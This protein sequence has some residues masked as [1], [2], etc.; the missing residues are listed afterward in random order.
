MHLRE[1]LE[2]ADRTA[3]WTLNRLP[4]FADAEYQLPPIVQWTGEWPWYAQIRR[5]GCPA[6]V[7]LEDTQ[8]DYSKRGIRGIHVG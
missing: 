4:C 6:V 3:L 1:F 8:K 2:Q 5:W 7:T